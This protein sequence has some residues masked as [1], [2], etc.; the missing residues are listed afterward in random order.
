MPSECHLGDL[1]G[2]VGGENPLAMLRPAGHG[3]ARPGKAGR[4]GRSKIVIAMADPDF[5]VL[6]SRIGEGVASSDTDRVFF[7]SQSKN[8][9]RYT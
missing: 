9:Y 7:R 6:R 1:R 8:H 5:A 3:R 2:R 4:A